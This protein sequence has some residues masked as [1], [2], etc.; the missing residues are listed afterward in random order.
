[1]SARS[2]TVIL[3][4]FP[5]RKGNST[6]PRCSSGITAAE[7]TMKHLTQ[8]SLETARDLKNAAKTGPG[9]GTLLTVVRTQQS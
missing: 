2:A 4:R 8:I 1:V 6:P 5:G 7:D 9:Y 3:G